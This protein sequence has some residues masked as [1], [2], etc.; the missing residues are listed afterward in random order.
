M[1]LTRT[2][3]KFTEAGH[4]HQ[5]NQQLSLK[6]SSHPPVSPSSL[7]HLLPGVALSKTIFG[8]LSPPSNPPGGLGVSIPTLRDIV[9]IIA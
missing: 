3:E 9:L 2:R 5:A 6:T 7:P 1:Q 4:L 8:C